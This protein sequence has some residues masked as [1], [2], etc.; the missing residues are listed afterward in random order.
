MSRIQFATL[1]DYPCHQQTVTDWLWQT[2][3]HGASRAFYAA[4]VESSLR[5]EGLLL[6]FIALAGEKLFGTAGLWRCDLL[7]LQDLTPW[8]AALYI[9]PPAR[10]Q[11]VG[12]A[13]QRH[14]MAYSRRAGFDVL[15]LYATF[16]GYY[17]RHGWEYLGDGID[18]PVQA[19]RLYRHRF[20]GSQA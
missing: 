2:F 14:V 3:G 7:S 4:I 1:A 10:G 17:E 9:D 6:T 8:L 20:A 11:G 12:A 19:V 16:T 13:L 15:Y 18:Y 5:N